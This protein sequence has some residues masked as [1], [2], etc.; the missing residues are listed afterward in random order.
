MS[1]KKKPN[2]GVKFRK[3]FRRGKS[4]NDG[5]PTYIYA[6]EGDEF[7]YIG[8]THSRIVKGIENIELEKNPNPEDTRPS[9]IRPNTEKDKQTKFGRKLPNWHFSNDDKGKVKNV[10]KKDK[11]KP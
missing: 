1:N 7:K 3:Q 5:H 6:K 10:I 9:Y 11:K 8:I 4:A 2:N